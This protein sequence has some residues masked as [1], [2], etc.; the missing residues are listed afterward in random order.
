MT[1]RYLLYSI[2]VALTK[3]FLAGLLL[4]SCNW[5]YNFLYS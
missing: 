3:I 2:K 1:V 5:F 4:P